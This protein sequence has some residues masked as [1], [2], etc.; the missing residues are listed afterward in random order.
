[1]AATTQ[2]NAEKKAQDELAK[3]ANN[4]VVK[5]ERPLLIMFYYDHR[6]CAID[7]RD[8]QLLHEALN[9]GGA[10]IAN[11]LS[12]LDILIH[13]LGGDPVGAYRVAQVI[14]DFT[15]EAAFLV[16]EY[17]YSGG[18][19]VCLAG[20]LILLGN[21][22]VLSPID[23]TQH[24]GIFRETDMD[25]PQFRDEQS[26]ETVVE[27]VAIDNFIKVATQARIEI[28]TEFRKRDWTQARSEVEAIML[29]KM[30]EQMGVVDVAKVF[31]EKN[32]SRAYAR[33]LLSCYMFGNGN[34]ATNRVIEGILT[35]LLT[36]APAHAFAMDYHICKDI[37]LIVEEMSEELS[38][39]CNDLLKHM[40]GMAGNRILCQEVRRR[41]IPYFQL[42][43]YVPTTEAEQA[44][45]TTSKEVP[46]V[47]AE[48]NGNKEER[49]EITS[50]KLAKS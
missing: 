30:I 35:R 15:K 34:R 42:F 17:S 16:P 5:R 33:E 8:V 47:E 31:R 18:T 21:H 2:D 6:G 46:D 39:D 19:L 9:Q 26:S 7:E 37:G 20:N 32:I 49:R 48:G 12:E 10:Q 44:I 22:A 13:T 38:D 25:A 11:P 27:L 43:P 28:E 24:R 50:G 29:C 4:V 36:E 41:L 3:L 14:R 45:L 1:L 23:I 40:K